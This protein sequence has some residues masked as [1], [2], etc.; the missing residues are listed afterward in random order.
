VK[1]GVHGC[2]PGT[3]DLPQPACSNADLVVTATQRADSVVLTLY[4]TIDTKHVVSAATWL[5]PTV[6]AGR[7]RYMQEMI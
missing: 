7:S 5:V 2:A 4:R 3:T 1:R 6:D